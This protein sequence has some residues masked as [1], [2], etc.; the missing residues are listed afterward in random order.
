MEALLAFDESLLND[1]CFP[2]TPLKLFFEKI[3]NTHLGYMNLEYA[4]S[5]QE[6]VLNDI[7][8]K[9]WAQHMADTQWQEIPEYVLYSAL[10]DAYHGEA[11]YKASSYS[12][13]LKNFR[14]FLGTSFSAFQYVSS[15]S[16]ALHGE[17]LRRII[18]QLSAAFS[19]N[20]PAQGCQF[21]YHSTTIKS[22][23]SIL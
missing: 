13:N 9:K 16:T 4:Q 6:L 20:L 17:T 11:T 5:F 19:K 21:F 3:A 2:S 10:L 14:T 23:F 12:R 15:T 1:G 8:A 18:V 7:A 22:V